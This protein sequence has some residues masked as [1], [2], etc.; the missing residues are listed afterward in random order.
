MKYQYGIFD[1]DLYRKEYSEKMDRWLS[2][3]KI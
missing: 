1:T 3:V 2:E